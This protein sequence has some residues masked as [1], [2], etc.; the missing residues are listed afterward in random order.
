MGVSLDAMLVGVFKLLCNGA[1]GDF[2]MPFKGS[3]G[4]DPTLFAPAPFEARRLLL[5]DFIR[6]RRF[7]VP[8]P[9]E[10]DVV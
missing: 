2:G 10:F 4:L 5:L 3:T 7:H 1:L 8:P 9:L 6:S